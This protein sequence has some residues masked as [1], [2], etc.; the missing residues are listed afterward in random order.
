MTSGGCKQIF[1][2]GSQETMHILRIDRRQCILPGAGHV[3][4]RRCRASNNG[5]E[6]VG[7]PCRPLRTKIGLVAWVLKDQIELLYETMNVSIILP[8][9]PSAL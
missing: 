7:D 6:A 2:F 1:T 9:L 4:T 8:T 5:Q 3:Q